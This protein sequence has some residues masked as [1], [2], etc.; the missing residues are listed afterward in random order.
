[1]NKNTI[2]VLGG[3]RFGFVLSVYL[4]ARFE[5]VNLWLP[6][7]EMAQQVRESRQAEVFEADFRLPPEI[8]VIS[9]YTF[10]ESGSHLLAV[11]VQSREFEEITE[12]ILNRM[13]RNLSHSIIIFTKGLISQLLRKKHNIY[14]YSGYLRH[15]ADAN[16]YQ[17]LTVAAVAGPS[18]L[19][20][21]HKGQ[22]TFFSLGCDDP[23][24][25]QELAAM[26]TTSRVH[27]LYEPDVIAVELGG[28]LKNPLAI[29]AGMA[30]ALPGSGDNLLGEVI[31]AGF[32]EM[33]RI[34]EALGVSREVMEGRSGLADLITTSVSRHSR[35]RKYG[36][37]FINKLA[38]GED[39]TSLFQ[40]VQ[41]LLNPRAYI[42]KEV[43]MPGQERAEGVFALSIILEIAKE[44][45]V[46]I[47]LYRMIYQ[48]LARKESPE[49]LLT[50]LGL[51]GRQVRGIIT[52][53]RR[54]PDVSH[55]SGSDF[56]T[57]I[58]KRILSEIY[59]S[60]GMVP[61]ILRQAPAISAQLEKNKNTEDFSPAELALWTALEKCETGREKHAIASLIEFY[62]SEI[63]DKY[64]PGMRSTIIKLLK[65]VRGA[66]G[67]FRS[68]SSVPHIGGHTDAVKTAA[69]R[70]NV[71]YVPTHKSHLD[72]VEVAFALSS[73]DLPLPRYAAGKD[74]MSS[75]F[76]SWV[77]KSM[78]AYAVDRKRTRNILYLQCLA[79]YSAFMMEAGIPSLVFPEGTRSRT[80]AISGIKTGLLSTAVEA[81]RNS[82]QEIAI[83]PIALSY[84]H[85]PE[86]P[87]F[88]GLRNELSLNEFITGRS[89]VYM[90]FGEP[91]LVSSHIRNESPSL[92]L[93][94]HIS[95]S[96]QQNMKI[97]PN[98]IT[99]RILHIN[100]GELSRE[101]ALSQI[102]FFISTHKLNYLITG[103]GEI[104]K[105]G[106]RSLME[107][108]VVT[109]KDGRIITLIPE[110]IRFY[111]NMIPAEE[112]EE[113][114]AFESVE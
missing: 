99:A 55:A 56:V 73:L 95:Q 71:L 36:Y 6:D 52:E 100:S 88:L 67:G 58:S 21:L 70:F 17:D 59:D 48:I 24:K 26:L 22:F 101:E 85:V 40:K 112:P 113:S 19:T 111:S 46:D 51:T 57:L 33:L 78:G 91:V 3:G 60:R 109:E 105:R 104:L 12:R 18:M 94:Y 29:A 2:T 31:A 11:A 89:K 41:L 5:K 53:S 103:S 107:K 114:V 49:A 93:A 65:P 83:V 47:P 7:D 13:P 61:R 74:L 64:Q 108:S 4:S 86:A 45:N 25:G 50:A 9:G 1:M 77:L 68:G 97:L 34:G 96:W 42:E 90:D 72:S 20:E 98:H 16:G 30:Q 87:V 84:E 15:F 39:R 76:R 79:E 35:N 75:P 102:D 23:E 8:E 69:A 37:N 28:V 32:A 106:L 81:Y 92:S 80:G 82:G 43:L 110:L 10:F 66:L 44:K 62:I 38:S 14:T 54:K 27:T 63:S